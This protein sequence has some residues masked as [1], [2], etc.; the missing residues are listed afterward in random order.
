MNKLIKV[1]KAVKKAYPKVYRIGES[2]YVL[3]GKHHLLGDS[4][5]LGET[6]FLGGHVDVIIGVAV[7]GRKVAFFDAEKDVFV[8]GS[9]LVFSGHSNLL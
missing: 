3:D 9:D 4:F 5:C 7:H 2:Y 8:F 1:S 6:G